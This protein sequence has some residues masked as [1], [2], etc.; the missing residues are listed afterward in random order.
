MD[1]AD[2]VHFSRTTWKEET[3]DLDLET[4]RQSG[5][6]GDD[7]YLNVASQFGLST[8]RGMNPPLYP[9]PTPFHPSIWHLL[10]LMIPNRLFRVLAF[11]N[12]PTIVL[13]WAATIC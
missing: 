2:C 8:Q 3:P 7:G 11:L 6:V 9:H 12:C 13:L 1:W 4:I 5:N 10:T